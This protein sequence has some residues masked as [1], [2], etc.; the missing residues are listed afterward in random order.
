MGHQ[1]GR[2]LKYLTAV[3]SKLLGRLESGDNIVE[4]AATIEG[5]QHPINQLVMC[6]CKMYYNPFQTYTAGTTARSAGV[7]AAQR[8]SW[9]GTTRRRLIN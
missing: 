3:D 8:Q 9:S 5:K 7:R 4:P 6:P 1:R 2:E